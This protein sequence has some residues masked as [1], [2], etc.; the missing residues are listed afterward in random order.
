MTKNSFGLRM[1]LTKTLF[2]LL[3]L[4][5]SV[6]GI[7]RAERPI[8]V[9]FHHQKLILEV[10]ATRAARTQGLM[11]RKKLPPNH[12]MLFVFPENTPHD[13]WMKNTPIPLDIAFI[14]QDGT[15]I[16]IKTM[17]PFST[18]I[19][20]SEKPCRYALEMNAGFFQHAHARAGEKMKLPEIRPIES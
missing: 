7:V 20:S 17:K 3:L 15:V 11:F 19:T 10:A 2:A 13:F 12:G 14:S 6:A 5:L 9:V 4:W 1:T 16:T 8:T 18:E